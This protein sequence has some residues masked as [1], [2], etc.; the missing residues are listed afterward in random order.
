MSDMTRTTTQKS[1]HGKKEARERIK[2]LRETI[3]HHRY[4]IHVL[5]RQ[6]VSEGALD[7]LKHELYTLE[8]EY[9]EYTIPSSPTQ[10]VGGKP[11]AKFE[12]VSHQHPMLSME[13]VFTFQELTEWSNRLERLTGKKI[14]E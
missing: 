6:E 14:D 10:R 12:K 11:L 4:V 9:P 8:Q 1:S 2:K 5:D 7:S 13:D 3:N